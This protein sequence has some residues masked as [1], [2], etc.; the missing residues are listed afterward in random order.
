MGQRPQ[1]RNQD[2]QNGV[3]RRSKLVF[4]LALKG[5]SYK[6]IAELFD[7][8]P[9]T[10]SRDIRKMRKHYLKRASQPFAQLLSREIATIDAA[11]VAAWESFER[12]QKDSLETGTDEVDSDSGGNSTKTITRRKNKHGDSTLLNVILQCVEKRSRLLGLLER[13][14]NNSPEKDEEVVSL[15]VDDREQLKGLKIVTTEEF[16]NQREKAEAG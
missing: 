11:E 12:S 9:F 5:K 8:T 4:R 7:V 14:S 1:R 13:E 6:E 10:V 16:N 2:A 3:L 15:V